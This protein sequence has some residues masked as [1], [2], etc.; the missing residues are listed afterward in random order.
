VK[1]SRLFAGSTL[2]LALVSCAARVLAQEYPAR[3][4]RLIVPLAPAGGMDTIA[5]GIAQKL[6]ESLGQ[7]VVVDNRSGGGG[8]IGVE[9]VSHST[10]DGYTLLMMSATSLIYPLMYK[11]K[12]DMQRDFVPIVQVTTQPYVIVVNPNVP[13]KSVSELIAYAKANPARLN[14]ASSGNGSLI[15]LMTELFKS[16]TSA[17]MTHVPYRGIGAAYPDLLGGQI[18]LIFASSISA[19]PLIHAGRVRALAVTGERRAKAL[20]E[21][22]TV[23]EAGVAGFVVNQWYA[24]LAP[25]GTP[26]A[27]VER[28]NREVNKSLQYPDII[29]RFTNDGAE[30]AGGTP[31]AVAAHMKKERE[32]WAKV[33]KD[34]GIRGE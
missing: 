26:R 29:Q 24:M 31:Q 16:T 34:A 30:A 8:V 28:L 15:H 33:I 19:M 10:P 21:L 13:V 12:Y 22:P 18:Q 23:I 20:P 14:F 17:P 2:V 4:I 9:T 27:I 11:A 32:K 1:K 7:S 6:T 5:R 25:A 3:P